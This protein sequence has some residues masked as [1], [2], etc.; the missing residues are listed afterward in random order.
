MKDKLKM[1]TIES[2][3]PSI[4]KAQTALAEGIKKS[5]D[6][7]KCQEVRKLKKKVKRLTRKTS[8]MVAFDKMAEEKKKPKKDRPKKED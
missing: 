5:E 4:T 8:K 2:L 3:K 6:A 1:A 7:A